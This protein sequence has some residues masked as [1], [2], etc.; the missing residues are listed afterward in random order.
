MRSAIGKTTKT[1][2]SSPPSN[3]R[4]VPYVAHESVVADMLGDDPTFAAEYLNQVLADADPAE[5]MLALRRIAQAF[6]G[7]PELARRTNLNAKS[8]YRTL[9]ARGNPELKSLVA[10]LDAVGLRLAVAPVRASPR[11]GTASTAARRSPRS[12]RS[13]AGSRTST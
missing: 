11:A 7:V 9:S 10:L 5:L 6:G 1:G 12:P 8:L 13:R 4:T 3:E 2:T